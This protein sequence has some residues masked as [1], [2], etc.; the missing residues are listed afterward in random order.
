MSDLLVVLPVLI[1]LLTAVLCIGCYMFPNTQRM[2]S[3]AGTISLLVATVFLFLEVKEKGHLV[4][5]LGGWPGPWGIVWV[6]DILSV[7]M[8]GVSALIYL[9]VVWYSLRVVSVKDHL[10]FYYPLLSFLMVGVNGA[11]ATGDLF[12]LYVWFEVMLI[13]S[14]VLMVQ[15]GK[16]DQLEGGFKY[17]VINL[18]ASL[19]FLTGIGIL[20][21]KLGTL[22]MA[23]VA[24]LMSDSNDAFLATTTVVLF[25]IAFGIKAA[26]F[27]MFFWLPASY[28]TLP[29]PVAALFAGLLTK[30]GV[31]TFIRA[32]TLLFHEKAVIFQDILLWIAAATM[33]TGVFGAMSKFDVKR[34]LSF[35]IISQIGYI[36]FAVALFTHFG[37]AASVFYT[38]HHIIVKSNLFLVGGLIIHKTG[39]SDLKSIGGLYKAAPLLSLLFA[40]PAMSLGGIPPLS[41]FWAKFA[42]I[43]AAV[44]ANTIWIAVVAVLV[45]VCTLYSMTKI[46]AEAFWKERPE[47]GSTPLEK[48]PSWIPSILLASL[49]LWIGLFPETLLNWS[50]LAADQLMNPAAYIEAVLENKAPTP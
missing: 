43:R 41:G 45:G 40:V 16:R 23:D 36:L 48:Q 32:F 44:E 9:A 6:A 8:I 19:I 10:R 30:V 37:L 31:Y 2:I 47:D 15:G 34:I 14:F 13:A 38:I 21:G 12:N 17:V 27:P 35:H 49:T 39:S 46:W 4:L 25:V 22:N 28:H 7:L 29:S 3:M 50:M 26:V 24:R 20:Y 18:F 42:V 11:F 33:I 5:E 1:P